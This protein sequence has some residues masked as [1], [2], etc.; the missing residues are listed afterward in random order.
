MGHRD[1]FARP[2]RGDVEYYLTLQQLGYGQP[3]EYLNRKQIN[4]L[5]KNNIKGKTRKFHYDAYRKL[6][7]L[8]FSKLKS[9]ALRDK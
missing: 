3:G 4:I 1:V 8:G 6:W 5:F 7:P 2:A 9:V